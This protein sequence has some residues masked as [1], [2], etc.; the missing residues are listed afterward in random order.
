MPSPYE[1]LGV[2]PDA[3]DDAIRRRYLALTREFSPETA[4]HQFAAIRKAYEAVRTVADRARHLLQGQAHDE[5]VET[6]IEDATCRT[7]RR[8]ISLDEL[9]RATEP[10]PH[11]TRP[12]RR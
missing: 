7:P 3:D 5:T 2:P 4:P 1:T 9:L 8:R 10:P 11:P 12:E 6:L